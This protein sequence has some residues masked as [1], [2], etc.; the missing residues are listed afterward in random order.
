[1]SSFSPHCCIA[2]WAGSASPDVHNPSS[3]HPP[4]DFEQASCMYI[5]LPFLL[6][7]CWPIES[8]GIPSNPQPSQNLS[9][10]PPYVWESHPSVPSDHWSVKLKSESVCVLACIYVCVYDWDILCLCVPVEQKVNKRPV[11]ATISHPQAPE[12]WANRDVTTA[13]TCVSTFLCS[14][15]LI[16]VCKRTWGVWNNFVTPS[17]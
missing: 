7:T 3:S 17:E 12:N 5:H 13:H 1:M 10:A 4:K 15:M 6:W 9:T 14:V 8:R 2:I 11:G 16:F